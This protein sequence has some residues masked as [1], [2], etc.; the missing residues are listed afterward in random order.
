MTTGTRTLR[1]LVVGLWNG[2]WLLLG[3]LLGLS[4]AWFSWRMGQSTE[5]SVSIGVGLVAFWILATRGLAWVPFRTAGISTQ[6]A[7]SRGWDALETGTTDQ[8]ERAFE[9][10]LALAMGAEDVPAQLEALHALAEVRR[11][12]GRAHEATLLRRR[13]VQLG[14]TTAESAMDLVPHLAGLAHAELDRGHLAAA[15]EAFERAEGLEGLDGVWRGRLRLERGRAYY[16]SGEYGPATRCYREARTLLEEAAGPNAP[17][18]AE[19]LMS[20]AYLFLDTGEFLRAQRAATRGLWHLHGQTDD[21]AGL[22]LVALRQALAHARWSLGDLPGAATVFRSVLDHR[23]KI[24]AETE[25]DVV[26]CLLEILDGDEAE[27]EGNTEEEVTVLRRRL[28]RIEERLDSPF[29]D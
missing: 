4:A 25:Q 11:W 21:M 29:S 2:L 3:L 20:E 15:L 28:A 27:G 8:A 9:R 6:R 16:L 5:L 18:L 1:Y 19:V 23:P 10:A 17:G 22:T 24:D 7:L 14:E 12:Q 26:R 13:A